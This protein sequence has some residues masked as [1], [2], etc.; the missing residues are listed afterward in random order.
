ML[1]FQIPSATVATILCGKPFYISKL[2]LLKSNFPV[3][4]FSITEHT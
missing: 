2:T 4:L 1:P 3:L